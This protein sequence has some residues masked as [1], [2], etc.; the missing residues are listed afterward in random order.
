MV[1]IYSINKITKYSV[2]LFNQTNQFR[3]PIRH[4]INGC[5]MSNGMGE[6]WEVKCCERNADVHQ[7]G[8]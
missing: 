5:W 7:K 3:E 4:E 6:K 8:L 1:I 2:I